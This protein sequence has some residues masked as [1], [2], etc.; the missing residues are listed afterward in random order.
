MR[1]V[2]QGA[3]QETRLTRPG[4]R[5]ILPYWSS[6]TPAA[7]P[8][9][10]FVL[11]PVPRVEAT[12]HDCPKKS[13]TPAQQRYN[14]TVVSLHEGR[15]R[16]LMIMRV[17][18]DFPRPPH[19]PGQ[20]CT[21]GLGYWEPRVAGCQDENA[22]AGRRDEARPP[23]VLDQ[24]LGPGRRRASSTTSTRPTGWSSTSCWSA[25][26]PTAAAGPDAAAVH[27]REGDRLQ[28]GEKITGHYTLE[29]VKPGDTVL[30][31]GTGTGEAPHNYMLWELL[32]RG[33][34]GE[35]PLGLL[36]PLSRATSATC[37]THDA[38]D[39]PVPELHVPAADDARGRAS[40]HKVYIQ[41][42]ITSG[43]LEEQLGAAARPGDDARLPVRQPEDDRRA[44]QGPGDRASDVPAAARRHRDP[45]APRL[46]GRQRRRRSSRATSTSKSTGDRGGRMA[47]SQ[48]DRSAATGC[49]RLLQTGQI[50]QVY[51]VV[52]PTSN[53]HF[54]M[55]LLLP[56]ARRRSRSTARACSTRPRS[57][58]KL[59]HAERH[60]HPQG[61]PRP[62]ARRT[63]SWSSSRPGSLRTAAA[64]EGLR[65]SSRSTRRKIFKQAATGLAYMNASGWV[66]RDVKP[67]NILV[68]ALGEREAHRLRDLEADPD[69]A[70]RSCSTGSR[71]PQGT[72]SYM[73]PGADPRRDARRPRP[74]S[75]ASAARCYE[76]MTGR[77]PFRG[78]I[79][80]RTC[81]SKHF[82]EK[83]VTAVGVQPRRHR[84]VRGLRPEDAGQEE[85]G[86]ARRTSTRC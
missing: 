42:L 35:D 64:G 3:G 40:T 60:P 29:P 39:A 50:V 41:D 58:T 45:G 27:A 20:Y 77:P 76:L 68:N 44:G 71:R 7:K 28:L 82:N 86:P 14:A 21:L 22:E 18:P 17:K 15:T 32:R 79:D 70:S 43:E 38:A 6:R 80:R 2:R 72:P 5:D 55:K 4:R 48:R 1:R 26:T 67:D 57:G 59:T 52:E 9:G 47:D 56:E 84:R 78:D 53:R 8:A 46:P 11:S 36:R 12:G 65:R 62:A 33:H 49:R 30:F 75:T 63:S 81:S 24:L 31:L 74:T 54:A 34:T 69:R 85:G 10:V 13:R 83:P 66:H 73:S 61:E 51:E 23:G 37:D 25:R 16:D 19:Q